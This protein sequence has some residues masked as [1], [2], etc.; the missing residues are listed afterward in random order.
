[1]RLCCALKTGG[2]KKKRKK[3][4][5]LR[6]EKNVEWQRTLNINITRNC[7]AIRSLR[8]GSSSVSFMLRWRMSSVITVML[9]TSG[10]PVSLSDTISPM[11][12]SFGTK[13]PVQEKQTATS[14][15]PKFPTSSLEKQVRVLASHTSRNRMGCCWNIGMS[16]HVFNGKHGATALVQTKTINE[17]FSICV[18]LHTEL[19]EEPNVLS[20]VQSRAIPVNV[21]A[22]VELQAGVAQRTGLW[23]GQQRQVVRRR[24]SAQNPQHALNWEEGRSKTGAQKAP[25][26]A[27]TTRIDFPTNLDIERL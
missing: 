21:E 18:T 11:R 14:S 1:M 26:A 16:G 22:F 12:R 15:L 13:L 25:T 9:R 3:K 2:E 5:K 6:E 10:T 4:K 23:K 17:L 19:G 20:R 27:K 8:L 7:T 24:K